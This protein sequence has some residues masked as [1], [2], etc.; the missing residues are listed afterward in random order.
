MTVA[1]AVGWGLA[2]AATGPA[3]AQTSGTAAAKTMS[4]VPTPMR[5][6]PIGP[7]RPGNP[8]PGGPP[9]SGPPPGPGGPWPH[10][11]GHPWPWH[12]GV[13]LWIS[14]RDAPSSPVLHWT[15]TCRPNGG[16]LPGPGQACGQLQNINRPFGPMTTGVLCSMIDFGPQTA[17]VTGYWYGSWVSVRLSRADGCQE[18]RWNR[19]ISALGLTAFTGEVN[20]GGP[21]QPGPATPLTH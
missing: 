5:V 11:P 3:F 8:W 7:A 9:P 13:E 10:W 4:S 1:A 18:A 6:D 15:L 12:P 14:L 21:M 16:T 19:F 17:T 20:P 2:G